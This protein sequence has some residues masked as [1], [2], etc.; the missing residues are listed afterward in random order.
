VERVPATFKGRLRLNACGG[1]PADEARKIEWLD[2]GSAVCGCAARDGSRIVAE[3]IQ[4]TP[5][6]RTELVKSFGL[7]AYA[8]HPLLVGGRVLGTLSFGTRTRAHFSKD[9]LSLMKAVA[10][11][12]AVA[13]ERERAQVA[14]HQATEDLK[15]SNRDLEQFAYVASHDLQEPLRAVGGYVKLLE[16]RLSGS[17]DDRAREFMAGAFDGALRMERLIHDLLAF[18]RVGTRGGEFVPTGLTGVLQQALAN[19][20]ASIESDGATIT[21]DPLPTLTVD[22]TQLMQVFQNL[23]G[24]AIKFRG[25]QPPRI[26]VGAHQQDGRWIFSVRDNGIGIDPQYLE[27][28]FQVFQRLHTRRKYPGTGIG[29]AICRKIVER[30]GGQIWVESQ[31]GQGSTFYFSLLGPSDRHLVRRMG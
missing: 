16:R 27:R 8:C 25:E 31:P 26:H 4:A 14:L 12:V 3:D 6:L 13:M 20:R 2:F 23:I 1:I 18:S 11:Q 28:I 17:L 7:Q 9:D 15:R 5:D 21:H 22:A 29:L 30:H 24:N 19:L 10:D